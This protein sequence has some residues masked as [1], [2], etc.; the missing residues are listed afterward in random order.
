MSR[1]QRRGLLTHF[2]CVNADWAAGRTQPAGSWSCPR[3]PPLRF[4]AASIPGYVITG[5]FWN[6]SPCPEAWAWGGKCTTGT[7]DAF[8]VSTVAVLLRE[9]AHLDPSPDTRCFPSRAG[10]VAPSHNRT[11]TP[12]GVSLAVFT[13]CGCCHKLPH[14]WW[15]S[16]TQSD[17]LTVLQS[18]VQSGSCPPKATGRSFLLFQQRGSSV[19]GCGCSRRLCLRLCMAFSCVCALFYRSPP[20]PSSGHSPWTEGPPGHLEAVC[21]LRP[22]ANHTGGD[23][24]FF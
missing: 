11:L 19:P 17:V 21:I 12:D 8:P 16:A 7:R 22:F 13:S 5:L 1:V 10:H 3:C 20:C 6:Y 2:M 4:Q 23:R 24:R 9:G 18:E 15:L 14:A